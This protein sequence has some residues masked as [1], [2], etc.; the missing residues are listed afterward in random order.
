MSVQLRPSLTGFTDGWRVNE[1]SH[2]LDILGKQAVEQ[3]D[4][5]RAELCQ[6]LVFLDWC[7]SGL[8]KLEASLLLEL[9]GLDRR[10]SKAVGSEIF[11]RFYTVCSVQVTVARANVSAQI[12]LRKTQEPRL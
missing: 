9:V 6:V 1:G 11:A 7:F 2:F 3:V 12:E 10:R 8:E 4:I 5:C